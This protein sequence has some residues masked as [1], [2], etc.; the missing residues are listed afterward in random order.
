MRGSAKCLTLSPQRLFKILSGEIWSGCRLD[1]PSL[2][3]PRVLSFRSFRKRA[4]PGSKLQVRDLGAIGEKFEIAFLLVLKFP[5]RQ[6]I[7]RSSNF[8]LRPPLPPCARAVFTCF[9]ISTVEKGQTCICKCNNLVHENCA[10]SV[11]RRRTY[12]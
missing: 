6:C 2:G 4:Q 12:E 7:T 5:V 11:R 8:T 9:L 10:P 1:L 3:S